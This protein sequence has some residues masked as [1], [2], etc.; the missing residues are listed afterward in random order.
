MTLKMLLVGVLWMVCIFGIAHD[1]IQF[2]KTKI[3]N[4][5]DK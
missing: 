3:L 2:F 5:K 4:R 1:T